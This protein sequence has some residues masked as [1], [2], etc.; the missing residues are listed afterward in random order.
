MSRIVKC[1]CDGCGAEIKENPI[2]IFMEYTDMESEE[3]C[4]TKHM[5]LDSWTGDKDYCENC[6][7][8]VVAFIKSLP[9]RNQKKM[10]AVNQETEQPTEAISEGN[11]EKTADKEENVQGK[12]SIVELL[13]DGKSIDEIVAITGCS[14]N[15]VH[16]AK[17]RIKN[18]DKTVAEK[19]KQQK[20]DEC[21]E[22]FDQDAVL[23]TVK[24][25]EVMMIGK[26]RR[27]FSMN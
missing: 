1:I 9:T 6:T 10:I 27:I 13:A 8:Q 12:L 3:E 20:V 11:E 2:A 17:W 19:Q 14:R 22:P 5:N 7:G 25:S 18:M 24:C 15:S 16:T 23:Q 26:H 4:L 21:S